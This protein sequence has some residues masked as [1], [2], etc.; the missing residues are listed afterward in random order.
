MHDAYSRHV[1]VQYPSALQS[2]WVWFALGGGGDTETHAALPTADVHP[3]GQEVH[4][5]AP[6]VAYVPCG[7][8]LHPF[9]TLAQGWNF[10]AEQT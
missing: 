2:P 10:P 3:C 7:Q 5:A 6:A 1:D 8:S 9:W 4:C